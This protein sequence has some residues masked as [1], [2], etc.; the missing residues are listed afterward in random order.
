VIIGAAYFDTGNVRKLLETQSGRYLNINTGAPGD[1]EINRVGI[2][3][4]FSGTHVVTW[5][6]DGATSGRT[7][8]DG[9]DVESGISV[10]ATDLTGVIALGNSWDGNNDRWFANYYG[11]YVA[12]SSSVPLTDAEI[13]AL[14]KQIDDYHGLGVIP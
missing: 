4:I 12:A 11:I 9:S 6:I 13:E 8:V 14:E 1:V 10:S 3:D 5:I 2:G 7:R